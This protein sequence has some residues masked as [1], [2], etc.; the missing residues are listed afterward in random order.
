MKGRRLY[1]FG[2]S[3]GR[4][5]RHFSVGQIVRG[6]NALD[7]KVANF[8]WNQLYVPQDIRIFLN[9]FYPTLPVPD[10]NFDVI[11]A[12]SVFTH[13]D[14]LESPW[15]LELRRILKPGGLLYV[16][17]HDDAYWDVMSESVLTAIR[18]SPNGSDV[19]SGSPCPEQ[20]D[21]IPLHA[22]GLLQLQRLPPARVHPP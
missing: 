6:I 21:G 1:D 12:F 10:E 9:G 5:F 8:G 13:I 18:S 14:E 22:R 7:F 15:L 3:T 17:I 2:G 19:T 11:T 20:R 4:V 16:T